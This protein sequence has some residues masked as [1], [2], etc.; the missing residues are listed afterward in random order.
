M[1]PAAH[2]VADALERIQACAG[3]CRTDSVPPYVDGRRW[4]G[5]RFGR[6]PGLA[7]LT[8]IVEDAFRMFVPTRLA[9]A[10]DKAPH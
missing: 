2:G 1:V 5:V 8:G 10:L 9:A 6:D 7:E 4:R 3:H